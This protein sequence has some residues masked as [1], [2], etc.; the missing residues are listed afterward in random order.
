M[1]SGAV[2]VSETAFISTETFTQKRF[3]DWVENRPTGD[4]TVWTN[5]GWWIRS[6][7]KSR[8]SI[9]REENMT[10]VIASR[11]AR[12]FAPKS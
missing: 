3:K 4:I 2:K 9:Q 11:L 5:T 8:F 6:G 1:K 10:T 7:E 12:S